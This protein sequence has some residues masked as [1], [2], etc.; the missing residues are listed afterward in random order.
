MTMME[1]IAAALLVLL[2]GWWIA[3]W[4]KC[5]RLLGELCAVNLA[6]QLRVTKR[7][8]ARRKDAV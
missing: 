6:E 1:R 8:V 4:I 2:L 5:A 7:S 3:P